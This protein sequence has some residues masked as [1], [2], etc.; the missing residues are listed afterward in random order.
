VTDT[1]VLT[2]RT[3]AQTTVRALVNAPIEAID[4]TG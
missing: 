4:I 2:D 1:A 3:S